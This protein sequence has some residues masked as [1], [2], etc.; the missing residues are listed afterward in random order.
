MNRIVRR[1]SMPRRSLASRTM[2]RRSATPDP[3]ALTELKW[4]LVTLAIR[5]AKVVLPVPGGPQRIIEG[6]RSASMLRRRTV[7]GPTMCSCPTKSSN[8][9][10][11]ILAANGACRSS[12][13]LALSSKRVM[14]CSLHEGYAEGVLES[15]AVGV[16]PYPSLD[17]VLCQDLAQVVGGHADGVGSGGL[18]IGTQL[19]DH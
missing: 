19:E 13:C 2:A 4:L 3:T 1:R 11:R 9:R 7:S 12:C 18:S 14:L 5:L 17:T 16:S 8:E 10:G 15:W 6:M